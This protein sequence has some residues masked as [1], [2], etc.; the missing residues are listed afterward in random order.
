MVCA[1]HSTEFGG[2]SAGKGG[3]GKG[4]RDTS[5]LQKDEAGNILKL[6]QVGCNFKVEGKECPDGENCKFSHKPK[7]I[8]ARKKFFADRDKKSGVAASPATT[9]PSSTWS[10]SLSSASW[11]P[12]RPGA[13]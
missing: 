3:G 10:V 2:K 1:T 11:P 7:D 12:S 13:P 6:S 4:D 5:H 9:G 8:K